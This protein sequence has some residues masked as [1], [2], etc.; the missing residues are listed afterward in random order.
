M[1]EIKADSI[2]TITIG[3]KKLPEMSIEE[4]DALKNFLNR[5]FGNNQPYNQPLFI[6]EYSPNF[7]PNSGTGDPVSP[8]FIITCSSK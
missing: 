7:A 1:T 6:K 8:P 3:D 2:I 4:I 5:K